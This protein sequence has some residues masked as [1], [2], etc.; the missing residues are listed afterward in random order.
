M[1]NGQLDTSNV[2]S[3][4][5]SL[6]TDIQS[7]KDNLNRF[8]RQLGECDPELEALARNNLDVDLEGNIT[9]SYL[10]SKDRIS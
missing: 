8:L 9:N 5:L 3:Y 6:W 7:Q 2:S 10:R 1:I 4:E